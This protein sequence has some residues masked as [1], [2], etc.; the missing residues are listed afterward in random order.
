MLDNQIVDV[1]GA[2]VHRVNDVQ[3]L[4]SSGKTFMVNVDIGTTGLLRRLGFERTISAVAGLLGKSIDHEMISWKYV[5]TLEES[6]GP[7]PIHLAV[8]H[9]ELS[10]LHPGELA[11]ILEDLNQYE[12]LALLRSVGTEASR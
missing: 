10:E 1:Q 2:K 4:T 7:D 8:E 11:D 6:R 9:R 3:L 5:Q 12:R